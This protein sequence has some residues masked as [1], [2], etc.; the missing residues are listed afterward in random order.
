MHNKR[1][2]NK[3]INNK[4]INEKAWHVIIQNNN[5]AEQEH[6]VC[7]ALKRSQAEHII[8]SKFKT[9]IIKINSFKIK[10]KHQLKLKEQIDWL[11]QLNTL[12]NAGVTILD[13]L[14]LIARQQNKPQIIIRMQAII[15]AIEQGQTL[16]EAL[17]FPA[18][19]LWEPWFEASILN[20]IRIGEQ[21]G[22][23][24]DMLNYA[25]MNIDRQLKTQ[26]EIKQAIRYPCF[27]IF[28]SFL[29]CYGFILFLIP[30]YGDL[31]QSFQ[32]PLPK[33]TKYLLK[34]NLWLP[35]PI[36][37]FSFFV[38]FL[39]FTIHLF[40]CKPEIIRLF[41]I[42]TISFIPKLKNIVKNQQLSFLCYQ[43]AQ[44]YESGTTL[45]T[46]LKDIG[47][48]N[49][50]CFSRYLAQKITMSIMNEFDITEAFR[51]TNAFSHDMMAYLAAGEE[52]GHLD[53]ALYHLAK[54]YQ[55]QLQRQLKACTTSLSPIITAIMGLLICFLFLALYLP[56]LSLG[57]LF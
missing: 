17:N 44:S 7:L 25:I 1:I 26:E 41:F 24:S 50:D 10:N 9:T 3:S 31:Y 21:N 30:V 15:R 29:I 38:L 45:L 48:N 52:S 39:I 56:L 46:A 53:Q 51:L 8:F 55:I 43:L 40:K 33:L 19:Q 12:L 36:I 5:T 14:R 28:V 27:L 42:K 11:S 6:I 20:L 34:I 23:L 47:Q 13:A 35:S 49:K 37:L 2:N 32:A 54:H 16:N 18:Q 57:S 4:S 22:K